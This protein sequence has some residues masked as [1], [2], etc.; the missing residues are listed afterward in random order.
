VSTEE[1]LREWN[2]PGEE[3]DAL[4]AIV[5]DSALEVHRALGPAFLEAAYDNALCHELSLRS[6]PLQRQVVVPL[7][8]KGLA[9]GEGR[10]DILVARA[11]VV[12]VKALPALLPV[13]KSQ[14]VSYL[15]ATGL[16]LG[17]LINF[18]ERYLKTG[19]RR[20]VLAR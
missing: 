8:Y 7:Q 12:E 13:H 5:V 9:I 15:K 4:A 10:I 1:T 20:V 2:E 19:V 14:V 6:V 3:V 16:S 17:L 18:G 11:L